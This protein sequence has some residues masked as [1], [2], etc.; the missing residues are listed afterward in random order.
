MKRKTK[1]ANN[2][3]SI[4]QRADGR[5]ACT[6]SL[7][8]GRRRTFYGRTRAAV[9]E[10]LPG[11][12]KSVQDGQALPD[13][14]QTVAQFLASWLETSARPRVRLTTF[15]VYERVVRLHINPTVGHVR[16]ARLTPQMISHLYEK[17]SQDGLSARYVRMVHSIM[18]GSLKMAVRWRLINVNPADSVDAPRL[19]RKEF[20]ALD[21]E[22]AGRLLDAARSD[23][24]HALYTLALTCGMRQAELL[25]LRWADVDLD[26]G[27]LSVRR[28]V[29]RVGGEWRFSEP[30]TKAGRRVITLPALAVSALR[31]HRRQQAEERLRAADWQ[32]L[33]LVFPNRRGAPIAKENLLRRSFWPLL[34]RA[35]LDHVRFHDLRHSCASLLLASGLHPKVVQ[36]RLGHST[37]AVTMDVY[38]HVMPTLQREAA[39]TFDKVFAAR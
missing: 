34:E 30:K 25:G 38:S 7:G 1:R 10:R 17:L 29:M 36:E 16:L 12:L 22:E 26:G 37:I 6:V 39:D 5:W 23:R 19:E 2:E 27:K 13:E 15:V 14:R 32:D 18:H 8:D 21:A 3:G 31:E 24:L 28:Q 33:G 11:A 35:G 20:R 9:A 4:F